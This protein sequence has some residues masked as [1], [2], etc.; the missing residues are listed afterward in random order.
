PATLR[1]GCVYSRRICSISASRMIGGPLLSARAEPA[2]SPTAQAVASAMARAAG[3]NGRTLV[4]VSVMAP[5]LRAGRDLESRPVCGQRKF[6]HVSLGKAYGK[7]ARE[8][9]RSGASPD[10]AR[11]GPADA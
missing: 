1:I 10:F 7:E 5:Q 2:A 4:G 11:K 6:D 3:L 9:G 8:Y